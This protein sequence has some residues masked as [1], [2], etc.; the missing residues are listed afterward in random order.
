MNGFYT[1]AQRTRWLA[2]VPGRYSCRAYAG[3][4]DVAQMSALSYAAARVC[5]PGTRIVIAEM[6]AKALFRYIPVVGGI[7]GTE[8]YA[9]IIADTSAE[10]YALL[11]GIGGEAFILEAASLAVGTCWVSGSFRRSAVDI[12]LGEHEKVLAVTPL[13][14]PAEGAG[15]PRKRKQLNEICTG[16]PAAWPLWAYNA[17]ECVRAAPSAVNR[18]P[19]RLSYAGRTMAL[20][21]GKALSSLDMGIAL[22]HMEIATGGAPHTFTWAEDKEIARLVVEE[23]EEE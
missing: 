10:R 4:P 7:A 21:A 8:K 17:A 19:W 6:D 12:A 2:A 14:V 9:A 13:G 18:Q 20:H 22:L 23:A 1:Q 11:A 3:A 16:D 5:L 15:K